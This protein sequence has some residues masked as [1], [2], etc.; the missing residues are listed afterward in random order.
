M[1][2]DGPKLASSATKIQSAP[3]HRRAAE[4]LESALRQLQFEPCVRSAIDGDGFCAGLVRPLSG[5]EIR[6]LHA[7]GREVHRGVLGVG[8]PEERHQRSE[9]RALL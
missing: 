9:R 5:I 8:S 3:A 4:A 7:F 6:A 2:L 1:Q